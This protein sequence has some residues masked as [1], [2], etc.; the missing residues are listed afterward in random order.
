MIKL[1]R[2][3]KSE[4]IVNAELIQYVEETPDTVI[5]LTTGSKILVME[6]ATTLVDKVIEY[7]RKIHQQ[8][9]KKDF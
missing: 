3:N 4:M 1:T 5:T 2:L 9:F 6:N 8:N 7:K